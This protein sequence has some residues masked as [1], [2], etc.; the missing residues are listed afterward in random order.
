MFLLEKFGEDYFY[1]F[2]IIIISPF[3]QNVYFQFFLSKVI[4]QWFTRKKLFWD[5][6][7]VKYLNYQFS[8]VNWKYFKNL[9]VAAVYHFFTILFKNMNILRMDEIE[10]LKSIGKLVWCSNKRNMCHSPILFLR[11]TNRI[12]RC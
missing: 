12:L 1:Y 4:P 8:I 2:F 5:Q 3:L 10:K 6:T 9:K 7:I 11:Q